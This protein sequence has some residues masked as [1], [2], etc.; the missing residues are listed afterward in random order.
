MDTPDFFSFLAQT[1]AVYSILVSFAEAVHRPSCLYVH[2]PG[3]S[4]PLNCVL[5][6]DLLPPTLIRH[7]IPY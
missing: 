7:Q 2:L 1:T 4:L 3:L 5:F 6:P